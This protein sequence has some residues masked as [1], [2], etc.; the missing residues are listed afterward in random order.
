MYSGFP[1]R[2]LAVFAEEGRDLDVLFLSRL[3]LYATVLVGIAASALGTTGN[4][5]IPGSSGLDGA[6]SRGV[7]G[8]RLDRWLGPRRF[9]RLKAN[10]DIGGQALEQRTC[11][12]R[13][14][15]LLFL[16]CE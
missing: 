9:I 10:A 6:A 4:P 8:T 12:T 14:R 1:P 11:V 16:R 7:V 15:L 5:R 3:R 13:L 2:L